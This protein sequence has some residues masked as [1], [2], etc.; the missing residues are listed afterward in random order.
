MITAANT[1]AGAALIAAAHPQLAPRIVR[2][3]LRVESARYQTDECRNVA[4]GHAIT[5]LGTLGPEA[6]QSKA[7]VSF[8]RR[9][10]ANPRPA[11]RKKAEAFLKRMRP[12]L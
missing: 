9:Q 3:I 10:L 4:I 8:V 6:R 7:V 11:A 12:H 2:A 5:A 1:I